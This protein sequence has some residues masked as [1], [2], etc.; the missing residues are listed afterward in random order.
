MGVPTFAQVWDLMACALVRD[1]LDQRIEVGGADGFG[2]VADLPAPIPEMRVLAVEC[3]T[4]GS[5]EAVGDVRYR[6]ARRMTHQ[7]MHV[8]VSAARG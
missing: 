8:I 7:N 6:H 1:V 2:P 5:F 4:R 3:V